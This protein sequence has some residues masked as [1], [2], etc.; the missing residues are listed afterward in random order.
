MTM[1]NNEFGSNTTYVCSTSVYTKNSTLLFVPFTDH[2]ENEGIQLN[3]LC[4][5]CRSSK[6]EEEKP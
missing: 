1:K 6:W 5:T 4:N 2:Y 3:C